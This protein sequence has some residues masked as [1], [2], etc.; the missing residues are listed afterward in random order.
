MR[1][2]TN[3]IRLLLPDECWFDLPSEMSARFFPVFRKV[4]SALHAAMRNV[5]PA[6][7]FREPERYADLRYALP[8]LTY[9]SSGPF[10]IQARDYYY[11][12]L[13]RAAMDRFFKSARRRM[14][15]TLSDARCCVVAAQLKDT[16]GN[17]GIEDF[18]LPRNSK[19]VM[20]MVRLHDI[21]R[22]PLNQM[23]VVEGRMLEEL[24]KL[25]AC[26]NCGPK[27]RAKKIAD[28]N[29]AWGV[30]LR[31]FCGSTDFTP[32]AG[33]LLDAATKAL[34]LALREASTPA[35]FDLAA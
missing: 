15:T 10:Q 18:Y 35:E 19:K 16:P 23:L 33:D 11:D 2:T 31:R 1:T 6:F 24:I 12:V 28:F 27:A 25:G 9:Q 14:F 7:Y 26:K 5:L 8:M 17:E 21:Y 32:A 13:N 22:R 20:R 3:E 30:L 29:Y 4:G 34:R